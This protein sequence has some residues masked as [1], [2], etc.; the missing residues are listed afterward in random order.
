MC[1]GELVYTEA[2]ASR[3][4]AVYWETEIKKNKSRKY[5]EYLIDAGGTERHVP[6]SVPIAG[7]LSP[8]GDFVGYSITA[9]V[10]CI[11]HLDR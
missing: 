9:C 3:I 11:L 6:V 4:E 10:F 8:N 1:H 7:V 2:L 5:I